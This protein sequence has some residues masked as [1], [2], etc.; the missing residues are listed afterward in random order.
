MI[1]NE[2]PREKAKSKFVICGDSFKHPNIFTVGIFEYRKGKGIQ[3]NFFEEIEVEIFLNLKKTP[4]QYS[5]PENFM[6]RGAWWAIQFI[7]LQRVR[8]D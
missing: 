4:L 6:G 7:G 5:C 3:K 1:Q 2:T 8:H